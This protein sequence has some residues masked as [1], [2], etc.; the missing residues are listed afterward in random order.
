MNS[1][2]KTALLVALILLVI[3]AACY[4][5][6]QRGAIGDVAP[7]KQNNPHREKQRR[8]D[9]GDGNCCACP[10]MTQAPEV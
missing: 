2:I 8:D 3:A 1:Q 7:L 9:Q 5:N 6:R 10:C 4:R